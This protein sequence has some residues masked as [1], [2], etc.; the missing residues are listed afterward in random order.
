MRGYHLRL[1]A[2]LEVLDLQHL[3]RMRL[4]LLRLE[5]LQLLHLLAMSHELLARIKRGW[6][7]CCKRVSVKSCVCVCVFLTRR[8]GGVFMS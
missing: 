3:V 1:L 5:S 6:R 2:R 8:G 7:T 4:A